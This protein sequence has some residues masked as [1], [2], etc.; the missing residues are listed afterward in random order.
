M[1]KGT[2]EFTVE[3]GGEGCLLRAR[4]LAR[5]EKKHAADTYQIREKTLKRRVRAL[6]DGTSYVSKENTVLTCLLDANDEWTSTVTE[7]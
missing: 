3:D 7:K 4:T 5:R 1:T 2:I 6:P